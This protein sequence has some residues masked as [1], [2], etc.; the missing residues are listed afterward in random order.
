[1]RDLVQVAEKVYYNWVTKEE[2]E[3]RRRKKE[4]KATEKESTESP[5]SQARG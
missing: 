4:R 5:D 1:M 3:E 2:K